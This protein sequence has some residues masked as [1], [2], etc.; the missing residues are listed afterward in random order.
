MKS[1]QQKIQ[2]FYSD[3][4]AAEN[5][6]QIP[7][8]FCRVGKGG[9]CV[10]FNSIT[11]QPVNVQMDINRCNDPEFGVLHEV[12]HLKLLITKKDAAQKHNAAFRKIE[13][14]LVDKYMYSSISFKH[15]A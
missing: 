12:A 11:M 1:Q 14:E 3:V 9:A 4:I 8:V 2:G 15:F 13:S 6:P 5:L 7:L 10:Q